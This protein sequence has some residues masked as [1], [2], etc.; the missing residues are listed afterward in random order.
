MTNDR[1]P[2]LSYRWSQDSHLYQFLELVEE[3]SYEINFQLPN[4][5][6]YKLYM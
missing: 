3:V 2:E 1:L 6:A 5:Q 4:V